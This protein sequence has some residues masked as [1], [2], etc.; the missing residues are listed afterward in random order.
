MFLQSNFSK[1]R[2]LPT[3]PKLATFGAG[4]FWCV[5]ACFQRLKGVN[6]VKSGYMGGKVI[7]PTYEAVC[8]GKT[9]K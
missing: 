8:S 4:C 6:T 1:L 3:M 9:G 2:N 5:E 7:D